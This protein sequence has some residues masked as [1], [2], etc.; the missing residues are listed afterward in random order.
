MR[1]AVTGASGFIGTTVCTALAAA[2]HESMPLELRRGVNA[3]L[4][5]AFD[6]VAHLAAIA[7]QRGT[8]QDDLWRV[9]VELAEQVGRAAA[10]AGRHMVFMSSVKVH[11]EQTRVPLDE[12]SPLRPADRYA[13]SKTRAEERLRAVPGLRLTILRPPLV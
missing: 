13:E 11:G 5:G 7:H 1:I 8:R 12:S 9:N 6:A 3:K 4:L 2:G 10:S